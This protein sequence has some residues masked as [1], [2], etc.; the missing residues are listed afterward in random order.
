MFL[1]SKKISKNLLNKRIIGN[2]YLNKIYYRDLPKQK[3][4]NHY[5]VFSLKYKNNKIYFK[6]ITP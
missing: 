6:D 1:L 5:Q 4:L 2:N 3:I